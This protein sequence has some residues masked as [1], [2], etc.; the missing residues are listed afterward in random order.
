MADQ[1]GP[2]KPSA[3]DDLESNMQ[4]TSEPEVT[5]TDNN[6]NDSASSG[7]GSGCL[8]PRCFEL[9]H[10]GEDAEWH[11]GLAEIDSYFPDPSQGTSQ[12]QNNLDS[13]PEDSQA[14]N[15]VQPE[16][17]SGNAPTGENASVGQGS[18]IHFLGSPPIVRETMP[19]AELGV[20]VVEVLRYEEQPIETQMSLP[21]SPYDPQYVGVLAKYTTLYD[22]DDGGRLTEDVGQGVLTTLEQTGHP[23]QTYATP[24]GSTGEDIDLQTNGVPEDQP[25]A[26]HDSLF[27]PVSTIVEDE[28]DIF[29]PALEHMEPEE[30]KALDETLEAIVAPID[31]IGQEMAGEH[32]DQE[33]GVHDADPYAFSSNAPDNANFAN[34]WVPHDAYRPDQYASYDPVTQALRREDAGTIPGIPP[35]T[36]EVDPLGIQ[37]SAAQ[38]RIMNERF[39]SGEP[40]GP[41][42]GQNLPSVSNSA[43]PGT[44]SALEQ[45]LTESANVPAAAEVPE[46]A[47]CFRVEPSENVNLEPTINSSIVRSANS[48]TESGESAPSAEAESAARNTFTNNQ[49]PTMQLPEYDD[50][51]PAMDIILNYDPSQP[52]QAP[53]LVMPV[54]LEGNVVPAGVNL[55]GQAYKPLDTSLLFMDDLLEIPIDNLDKKYQRVENKVGLPVAG[56]GALVDK[57]GFKEQPVEIDVQYEDLFDDQDDGGSS[58]Q[59]SC[60]DFIQT[61]Q[62]QTGH[63]AQTFANPTAGTGHDYQAPY[64]QMNHTGQHYTATPFAPVGQ[65][66]EQAPGQMILAGQHSA[67]TLLAQIGHSHGQMNLAG[68][69]R[70]ATPFAQVGQSYQQT[71]GQVNLAGHFPNRPPPGE[72]NYNHETTYQQMGVSGQLYA[73]PPAY[74][75][76]NHGAAHPQ[77]WFSGQASVLPPGH[78]EYD[79]PNAHPQMDQSGQQFV[80]PAEFI[81]HNQQAIFQQEYPRLLARI[82]QIRGTPFGNHGPVTGGVSMPD[83]STAYPAAGLGVFPASATEARNATI[84]DNSANENANVQG[85]TGVPAM[86]NTDTYTNLFHDWNAVSACEYP[87]KEFNPQYDQDQTVPRTPVHHQVYVRQIV[88]A[89]VDISNT[90]DYPPGSAAI[91]GRKVP[92]AYLNFKQNRYTDKEL[93]IAAW[94]ILMNCKEKH[95]T[96]SLVPLRYKLKR[97]M[98]ATFQEVVD[99]TCHALSVQKTIA[100]R[101]LDADFSRVFIED[102]GA[103]VN[104]AGANKKLNKNKA[105][106]IKLGQA[107]LA[108]TGNNDGLG[109]GAALAMGGNAGDGAEDLGSSGQGGV[110]EGTGTTGRKKRARGASKNSEGGPKGGKRRRRS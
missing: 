54:V 46:P 29:S 42:A 17:V 9:N 48:N 68:Q 49:A 18:D 95:R 91:P 67:A 87:P 45:L 35:C 78:V 3:G 79:Y 81:E 56:H 41:S 84:D 16:V 25:M 82:A 23:G 105:V 2:N 28:M 103:H 75:Q 99:V 34:G 57:L 7:H 77:M 10:S 73:S 60:Q 20:A 74:A 83:S 8:T 14:D 53:C 39:E 51:P 85:I 106:Q 40:F 1:L 107:A 72:V 58:T 15:N 92:Q 109:G 47:G 110:P 96:G 44:S 21:A 80:A 71:H 108:A 88:E 62:Q 100:K 37:G 24:T 31:N 43:E 86:V 89:L 55:P 36:D 69:H 30:V 101:L 22:Q 94:K 97:P 38:H 13:I 12:D 70:A 63:P 32:R 64:G 11:R 6:D 26:D 104:R 98:Y 33:G 4:G 19:V 52:G 65:R 102:P 90:N 61:T 50:Q 59:H 76:Q 93:Q 5:T 27:S 66:Y